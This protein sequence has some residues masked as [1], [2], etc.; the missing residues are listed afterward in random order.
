MRGTGVVIVEGGGISGR[1][2]AELAQV[3]AS[4]RRFVTPTDVVEALGGDADTA[5]K[6]LARWAADGWVRRVRR[7]L[8]IGVPVDATNPAAWSEDALVV[9]TTVWSPCY[10]TGWTAASQWGLTEQVFR[11]IVLKT[12]ARVRKSSVQLLDHDYLVHHVPADVL[13][14][15][16]KT[17][18]HGN[19]K[20]R[21]ADPARTVVDILDM[22]RIGG[23]IRHGAEVITA[24][25]DDHDPSLLI[26][27]GDRLGNRA[28][29]KRLGYVVEA[30][31]I[32]NPALVASCLERVSAGIS[33]LD[34]DGPPGG[35]QV[36][37]WGLRVNVT[38]VRE[39]AS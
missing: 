12:S 38:V 4:G 34:P 1:G 29:F 25:I 9:A 37:R 36:M 30:L 27:Y 22:P 33:A 7:G 20:L 3:L 24:Y 23:G 31:G 5:A 21:F 6:K 18:W 17:E 14:W 11:T 32:D 16:V 35:R 26:E 8:Y 10:F 28:V 39:G 2:R 15:G 13:A 19:V